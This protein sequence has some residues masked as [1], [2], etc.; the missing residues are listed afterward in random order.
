V[1][2]RSCATD[3]V[4]DVL[5]ETTAVCEQLYKAQWTMIL[6]LQLYV[7]CLRLGIPAVRSET[8]F[9]ITAPERWIFLEKSF[10]VSAYQNISNLVT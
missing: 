10:A 8:G 7:V 1:A 5:L 2:S 9:V 3:R 6:R 4:L